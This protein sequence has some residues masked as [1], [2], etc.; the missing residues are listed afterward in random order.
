MI[1]VTGFGLTASIGSV[2]TTAQAKAHPVGVSI[3][4]SLGVVLVW[5]EID[6]S[7]T[8]SWSNVDD[9]QSPSYSTIDE[10]QTADWSEVA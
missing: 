9:S 8:P 10:S 3:T 7:E 1:E 6:E 4:T 2:S 5:G